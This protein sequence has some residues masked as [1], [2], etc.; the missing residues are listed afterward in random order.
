M[1]KAFFLD[2][3]IIDYLQAL[4]IQHKLVE[5]RISGNIPDTLMLLQHPHV[6]TIG[7]RGSLD[8]IY[9][10]SIPYYFVERGG[11]VTYHGPGQLVGYLIFDLNRLKLDVKEFVKKI[12]LSICHA[13]RK[14]GIE[15]DAQHIFPGVW[16][17]KRKIASIGI[18][19]KNF[20]TFHGF[21]LNVNTDLSYF[22]KIMPCGLDASVMTSMER[23]LNKKV[24]LEEVKK[25][26]LGG[27]SIEF[28]KDFKKINLEEII[29]KLS[30]TA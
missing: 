18:A 17:K 26:I 1:E 10:K 5:L 14:F 21:A 15:C 23:E 12:E 11:D 27:F 6:F 19:L 22:A 3:D 25:H 30:E 4:D 24:N 7:R 9:D 20:I 16:T 13:I 8:H 29:P 2:F 28:Q